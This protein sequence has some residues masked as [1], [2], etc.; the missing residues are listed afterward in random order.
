MKGINADEDVNVQNH[1]KVGKDTVKQMEGQAVFSYSFKR[2]ARVKTL[3]SARTV[4]VTDDQTI[5]PALLFQRFLV[6]SQSGDL[7]LDKVLYHELSPYPPSLFEAKYV[8]H[9]PDKAPLL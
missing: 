8:L 4:K 7:C 2:K 1:F 3:A 9:K 6:V 5:D